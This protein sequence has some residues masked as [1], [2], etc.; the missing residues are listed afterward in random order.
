MCQQLERAGN[1]TCDVLS[2]RMS[3]F[4]DAETH[5][6][7]MARIRAQKADAKAADGAPGAKRQKPAAAASTKAAKSKKRREE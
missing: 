1:L 6:E 3:C 7:R 5:A 4:Q 2:L